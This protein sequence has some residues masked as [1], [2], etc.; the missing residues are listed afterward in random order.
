[1]MSHSP[2]SHSNTS[3]RRQI[4]STS[5]IAMFG[6]AAINDIPSLLPIEDKCRLLLLIH[7][8]THDVHWDCTCTFLHCNCAHADLLQRP[9]T[10][11]IEMNL[12]STGLLFLFPASNIA[13]CLWAKFIRSHAFIASWLE[14]PSECIAVFIYGDNLISRVEVG[15]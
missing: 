2:L 1:M 8:Y 13:Y 3:N 9:P 12:K 4:T 15:Y 11:I 10:I 5:V 14:W 6:V 7:R